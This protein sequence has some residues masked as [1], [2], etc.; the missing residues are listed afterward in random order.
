MSKLKRDR[1]SAQITPSYGTEARTRSNWSE[2]NKAS[3]AFLSELKDANDVTDS[4]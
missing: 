1:H 2:Q 3:E 4:C